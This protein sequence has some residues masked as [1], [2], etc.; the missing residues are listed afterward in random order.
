MSS[1][2]V[3]GNLTLVALEAPSLVQPRFQAEM[4]SMSSM[5]PFVCREDGEA[6]YK[7]QCSVYS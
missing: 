6:S 7:A 3:L 5:S 1:S 2:S 4:S